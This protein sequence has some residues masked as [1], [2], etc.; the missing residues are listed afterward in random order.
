MDGF[1]SNAL[2]N[3]IGTFVGAVLALA[4]ALYLSSRDKKIRD[5]R[6]IQSVIDRLHRSRA[7]RPNQTGG[8]GDSPAVTADREYCT[9]SILTTRER[10][11]AVSDELSVRAKGFGGLEAMYL[12]CLRYLSRGKRNPHNYVGELMRLREA[13]VVQVD[14][15]CASD[16]E[17]HRRLP[18]GADQ[19]E[20]QDE[21]VELAPGSVGSPALSSQ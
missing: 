7:L 16:K 21:V 2:A 12:A 15:L 11:A 1:L 20:D 10:I 8:D 9:K 3:L 4:I 19:D 5:R 17:L 18:G 6:L 13:L 14:A